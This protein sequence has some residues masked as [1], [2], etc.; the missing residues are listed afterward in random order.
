MTT[1][2]SPV[3]Q[4]P[5]PNCKKRTCCTGQKLVSYSCKV[6]S[7]IIICLMLIAAA[8]ALLYVLLS[9]K[10]G[11][12]PENIL[13]RSK[14]ND[15]F[16]DCPSGFLSLEELFDCYP[17]DPSVGRTSCE[18]R[19]CCYVNQQYFDIDSNKTVETFDRMPKCVYPKNYGYVS[20]GKT[21]PIFN[22]FMLPLQRIPAPSRYGDDFQVVHMKVEMQTTYRLRIKFYDPD[23]YH[24]EV[25]SPNIHTHTPVQA[26]GQNGREVSLYSVSYDV[27]NILTTFKVRRS[28]TDTVIFDTSVGALLLSN[29]F[30]ELTTKL[31]S[32]NVYGF[33]QHEKIQPQNGFHT[34]TFTMFTSK[35]EDGKSS[36]IHPM[37]MCLE[38][39]GNAY[40]VLLL[41]SNAMEVLLHPLPAVTFRTVG[42]ILDFYIFLGPSP[43][44]VIQQY[45]EAVGRSSM[46]PYWSLG[47]QIG[48]S[49]YQSIEEIE[50]FL[51]EFK[52][53]HI[54]VESLVLN[55]D[56]LVKVL[57]ASK[58]FNKFSDLTHNLTNKNHKLVLQLE[59]NIPKDLILNRDSVF[60]TAQI[61]DVFISDK[62]GWNPIEGKFQG[63]TVLYP[64]FGHSESIIW[65]SEVLKKISSFI[66]FDGLWLINNEP[67]SSVDGSVSG[68]LS[69]N[70]NSPPYVP[71]AL[72]D[73]I[74]HQT[75][76]MDAV[77]HWRADV[78][79]HYDSHNLY[80]H[81]MAVT[82]EQALVSNFPSKRKLIITESTF[83]GTGQFAGHYF[84]NVQNN[85]E[86]LRSSVS[87]VLTLGI[88]GI[89]LTGT[90]VCED[91]LGNGE[92]S[93]ELCLRWLQCA[94]FFPL[95]Q[96]HNGAADYI[97]ELGLANKE[98][99]HVIRN[100]LSRRYELFPQLYT[101][102]Y[103]A[104]TKGSTVIRSLF[105]NFPKDNETYSITSQFMW[106]S[107]LLISPILEQNIKE[108]SFY[109]PQ[110]IWYDFYQGDPIYSSGKWYTVTSGSFIDN[111]QPAMMHIRAGHIIT[112][113]KPAETITISRQNPMSI[114]VALDSS[115]EAN[116]LLYWDDGETKNSLV[117]GE[118][119]LVE[120]TAKGNS[121]NVTGHFGKKVLKSSFYK[122]A[123]EQVR[124]MGLS[125]PPKRVIID[126]SYILSNKQY[127]WNYDTMVLDLKLI[128]IPLGRKTELQW[129]F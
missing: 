17:D 3:P 12:R 118:Y 2:F 55:E 89:I 87:S 41:N 125:R 105:H 6:W 23:I 44:E 85:W 102:L 37:Y 30:L 109:L 127:H 13:T 29:Q 1:A 98:S 123:I 70:Y 28:D 69:D 97:F 33:K 92:R 93:E 46:P 79:S 112:L 100:A 21:T 113:Q 122:S 115:L 16:P 56:V 32:S 35:S 38:N 114:L 71:G 8:A 19:G 31:A 101:L 77:L 110:G 18:A 104:H 94:I 66:E 67:T 34:E 39:D 116:G 47:L 84:K 126:K 26:N 22:G 96:L 107:S 40:G 58:D 106:G 128:L 90:S 76:C 111:K 129:Y 43:E 42:G 25:P 83:V 10:T 72:G 49:S 15:W 99:F 60:N 20:M 121:L 53:K 9:K 52:A 4:T 57:S 91:D 108:L 119:L 73:K 120:Y 14:P 64:D 5:I 78:M 50:K 48:R 103:L 81:S 51:D 74:Y 80:A 27:H 62:W 65:W 86:G 117:L 95:L 124:I 24:F 82:T 75:L 68:C 63:K 88:H 36:N 45:T 59:A 7:M 11:S 61:N 54:P